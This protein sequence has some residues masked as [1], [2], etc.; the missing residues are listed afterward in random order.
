MRVMLIDRKTGGVRTGGAELLAERHTP[1]CWAW[2]DLENEDPVVEAALLRD[3]FGIHPLAIQDAQ[4]DRHPA[5]LEAFENFTFALLKGLTADTVDIDFDTLQIALFFGDEFLVSRRVRESVS[6]DGA[7]QDLQETSK[8]V[9]VRPT[10]VVYRITRRITD[11][12]RGIL[13]ALELRLE[14]LEQQMYE[15]ADDK[16]LAELM[17]TSSQLKK[18][19]RHLNYQLNLMQRLAQPGLP[20]VPVDARHEFT[21]LYENNE[22]LVSLSA[23]YQELINDLISGYISVSSHR[24]NQIMKVLTIVTVLFLPLGLVAGLYGM[25]FDNMPELHTRYGYFFVLGLM[26][27]IVISLLLVFRRKRWI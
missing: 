3:Q 24:L 16:L 10:D 19:R 1:G 11:R 7:W 4:R 27:T 21:D 6:I 22:R 8:A 20:G 9:S 5:K 2:A 23:L 26:V 17:E 15:R 14:E 13:M 25:N 18:L 12:F